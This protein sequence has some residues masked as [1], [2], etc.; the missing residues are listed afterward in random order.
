MQQASPSRVRGQSRDPG[1]FNYNLFC[2]LEKNWTSQLN[3]RKYK[4]VDDVF[5]SYVKNLEFLSFI[6]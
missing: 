2:V 3:K 6:L 4:A 1:N 5:S